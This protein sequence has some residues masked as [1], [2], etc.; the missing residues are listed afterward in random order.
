MK[1]YPLS[2][3]LFL[4]VTFSSA[5]ADAWDVFP[6]LIITQDSARSVVTSYSSPIELAV[7]QLRVS[8]EI[9]ESGNITGTGSSLCTRP[10]AVNFLPRPLNCSANAS[11]PSVLA[12]L[13]CAGGTSEGIAFT[14]VS[15]GTEIGVP[16]CRT[17]VPPEGEEDDE[18]EPEEDEE[19]DYEPEEEEEPEE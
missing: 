9:S 3:L 6:S 16:D 14:L 19:D 12:T 17:Y 1:R 5:P 7:H 2:T 4:G 8:A 18:E 13:Y 15:L 11:D 10:P